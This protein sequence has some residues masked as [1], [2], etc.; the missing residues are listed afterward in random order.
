MVSFSPTSEQATAWLRHK[1]SAALM[2]L[3]T[4]QVL[5]TYHWRI[6]L[7]LFIILAITCFYL[8][9]IFL[10]W[11]PRY[12]S[13]LRMI[14]FAS[15]STMCCTGAPELQL[16]SYLV[17]HLY[18][19]TGCHSVFCICSRKSML[20]ILIDSIQF[21][22]NSGSNLMFSIIVRHPVIDAAI[23]F[24]SIQTKLTQY[25]LVHL[26]RGLRYYLLWFPRVIMP[27]VFHTIH[28]A[29]GIKRDY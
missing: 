12:C 26:F 1:G 9:W 2:Y 10:Y 21:L 27:S 14:L 5:T 20:I 19:P 23:C 29:L 24:I 17:L 28:G 22:Q 8:T 18:V 15:A 7:M 3:L 6:F 16:R 25:W 11:F 4:K 13:R